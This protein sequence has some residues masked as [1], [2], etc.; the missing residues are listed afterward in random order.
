LKLTKALLSTWFK[1]FWATSIIFT[2]F[3]EIDQNLVINMVQNL[4]THSAFFYQLFSN[5]PNPCYKRDSKSSGPLSIFSTSF[6]EIDHSLVIIMVQNLLTHSAFF[7]QLF[8]KWIKALLSK[9]FKIFWATQY[10]YQLLWNWPKLC[11]QH[12]SKSSRPPACCS[13]IFTSF[14]EIDQS[15]VINLVQNL[16]NI[17]QY[18]YQLLWNLAK[19]C[20]QH[21]SKSSGPPK[22]ISDTILWNII[23]KPWSDRPLFISKLVKHVFSI[24]ASVKTLNLREKGGKV[25]FFSC[26][27]FKLALLAEQTTAGDNLST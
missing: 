8:W 25:Q 17:Q 13:I 1:I 10:F 21:G 15:L 5:W 16:L 23:S 18:F 26:F 7:Y 27:Y 6:F 11:Y 2:S 14:F 20:C 24:L 22:E 9:W 19:P 3:F 12:G 4:L